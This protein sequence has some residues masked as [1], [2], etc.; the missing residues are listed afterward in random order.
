[1]RKSKRSINSHI[2]ERQH[3]SWRQ[4]E[5]KPNRFDGAW[6]QPRHKIERI[7]PALAA[8]GVPQAPK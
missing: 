4:F 2:R 3:N 8:E 5:H 7:N 1:M 6:L